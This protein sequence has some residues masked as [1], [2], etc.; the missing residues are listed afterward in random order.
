M[1]MKFVIQLQ[2]YSTAG[3]QVW[4]WWNRGFQDGI[5]VIIPYILK[6]VDGNLKSIVLMIMSDIVSGLPECNH[7]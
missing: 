1:C 2:L 4:P 6:L 7:C 5:F 3:H